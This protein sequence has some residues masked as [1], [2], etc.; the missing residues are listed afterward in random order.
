MPFEPLVG[1]D[2]EQVG[3]DPHP[4][5]ASRLGQHVSYGAVVVKVGKGPVGLPYVALDVIVEFG[6]GAGEGPEVRVGHLVIGGGAEVLHPLVVEYLSD[7][8]H[9]VSFQRGDLILGQ[10]EGFGRRHSRLDAVGEGDGGALQAEVVLPQGRLFQNLLA[11][12][13]RCCRCR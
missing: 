3:A 7:V 5:R 8:D 13:R 11:L 4:V 12:L 2:H 9:A 1:V 6:C 10:S